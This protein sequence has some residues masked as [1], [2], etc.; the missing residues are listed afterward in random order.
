MWRNIQNY[1]EKYKLIE[2]EESVVVACSGGADSIGLLLLLHEIAGK[3]DGIPMK[4]KVVHVHHG[5]RKETADHDAN[6]VKEFCNQR[7][8]PVCIVDQQ[9]PRYA[10]EHGIS[11]E[12]AGRILRYNVLEDEAAKWNH[13]KIAIAHHKQDQAE[14]ILHHLLRG[15]GLKGLSGIRP[16]YGNRIRPL[17]AVNR[18]EIEQY[19][20]ERNIGWCEDETNQSSIYTRNRLRNEIIPLLETSVNQ[21][22]VEHLVQAGELFA[23]SNLYF[24]K[25]AQEIWNQVGSY[26]VGRV[27][28]RTA[29]LQETERI[30]TT[31][32]FRHMIELISPNQ[33]N[34]TANH[35]DSLVKLLEKQ[36][37]TR[38]DLPNG[39]VA[40][41]EYESIIL[42]NMNRRKENQFQLKKMKLEDFVFTR[43]KWDKVREIP[44]NQYTKWVDYDKIKNMLSVR[45]RQTG[46]YFILPTGGKKSLTRYMIDE[47]IPKEQR[48]QIYLLADGNHIVWV[49]GYRMSEYY[50]I[51][52]KT[53]EILQVKLD[54]GEEYG[55]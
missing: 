51:T 2:P 32:V 49:I 29:Y 13:A 14:T 35:Y 26:D 30:I 39:I 46:D 15:S 36:V 6:F 18:A 40:Y 53:R 44:K 45:T 11:E 17:L 1:I 12:E 8:I 55:R 41:R 47:K 16:I 52:E 34:I 10:K 9:V 43:L 31:Y 38:L 50:K 33:K 3:P 48:D 21:Q 54:K 37:G 20:C 7:K 5:I 4:L 28:V 27:C 22:V 25:K 23:Q 24:E 19:L 42:E